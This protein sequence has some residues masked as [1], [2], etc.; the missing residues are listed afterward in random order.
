MA[1]SFYEADAVE[2]L[3]INLFYGWGYNFYR[4]EN[5]LRADDLLVRAKASAALAGARAAV[6]AAESVY[7]RAHL[8]TPSREHPLPTPDAVRDA[9]TLESLG[10]SLGALEGQIRALPVPETDRVHQRVRGEAETLRE[11]LAADAALVGLA[12]ILRQRLAT[13]SP[14]AMLDDADAIRAA[15]DRLRA[16]LDRRRGLLAWPGGQGAFV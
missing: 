15:M 13:A 10:R 16:A 11:L 4:T 2:Q 3:A 9:R 7:R 8:A 6:E 14:A 1:R 5:Q 12:E